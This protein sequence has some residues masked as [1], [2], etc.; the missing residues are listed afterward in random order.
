MAK[1]AAAF[2]ITFILLLQPLLAQQATTTTTIV[3]FAVSDPASVVAADATATTYWMACVPNANQGCGTSSPF[4]TYTVVGGPST[5]GFTF[6]DEGLQLSVRTEC[7][8]ENYTPTTC[9]YEASSAGLYASTVRPAEAFGLSLV[10][11]TITAGVEKLRGAGGGGA[12]A[13]ATGTGAG[14][15]ESMFF[16][17]GEIGIV[18]C[19]MEL[20]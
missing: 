14:A 19:R 11:V 4:P 16:L 17:R 3:D 5:A 13:S 20:R 6:V 2:L 15:D 12:E 18:S 9:T 8:C 10:V 7:G 1:R